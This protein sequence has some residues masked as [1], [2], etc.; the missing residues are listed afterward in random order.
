MFYKYAFE[1]GFTIFIFVY[2]ENYDIGNKLG[3]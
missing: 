3:V 1:T 2:S